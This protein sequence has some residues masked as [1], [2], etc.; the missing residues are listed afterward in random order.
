VNVDASEI[1][2]LALD[3]TQTPAKMVRPLG[4]VFKQAGDAAARQW[5]SNA[6][7]TS[8]AHGKWY[9]DSID[10]ESKF[11][12]GGNIEVEVGPNAAKKQGGMGRGFEFGSVNQP[13]HLDGVRAFE[14]MEPRV[15]MMA[16]AAITH[17][18]P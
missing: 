13:P 12:L 1:F 15:G 4:D 16:D 7:A 6:R 9:P 2:T 11:T 5:A 17:L 8:G 3:L 18:M 10:A 14:A